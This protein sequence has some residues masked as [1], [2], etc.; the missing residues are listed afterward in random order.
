MERETVDG[1]FNKIYDD[2]YQAC[3]IYVTCKCRNTQD[4]SDILQE[5]YLSIYRI[6]AEKGTGYIQNPEAYVIRVAKTNLSKRYSFQDKLKNVI[7]LF[8]QK[9]HDEEYNL[10]D[11]KSDKF[12]NSLESR[13]VHREILDQIWCYLKNKP[14]GIQKVFLLFYYAD[15]TIVEIARVLKL[16]ESTVKNR[17]YRTTRE[18]REKFGQEGAQ[19]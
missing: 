1:L 5:T 10:A 12:E 18:I 16:N 4:I 2:T 11:L 14:Q 3:L 19:L 13:V 8:G 6:L 15:M 7:P 9:D 17:L